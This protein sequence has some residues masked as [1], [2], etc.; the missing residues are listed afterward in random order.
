MIWLTDNTKSARIEWL[1]EQSGFPLL[2]F[3]SLFTNKLIHHESTFC[4]IKTKEKHKLT[5]ENKL[6]NSRF[7]L[8]VFQKGLL[9]NAQ[10]SPPQV[11]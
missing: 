10:P 2:E 9:E 11:F 4:K 1:F 3:R 8:P 7:F 5:S 6:S